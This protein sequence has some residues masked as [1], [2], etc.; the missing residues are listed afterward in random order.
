VTNARID[1]CHFD[2]LNWGFAIQIGGWIYGV[3]DHNLMECVG[4]GIGRHIDHSIWGGGRGGS[5]SWAD[6]PY[7]GSEKFWFVEDNTTKGSG[8]ANTSGGTDAF[9][10]GRYVLRHNYIQN[11]SAGGHG[12]VGGQVGAHGIRENQVYNNTFNWTSDHGI[13]YQRSGI[14]I[15][16]DNTFTGRTWGPP[17]AHTALMDYR[18][19][20]NSGLAGW[21]MA[22]GENGWDNNDPHGV[23]LSGTAASNTT[24]HTFTTETIMAPDEFK[25]M[26]VRNDNPAAACYL[27]SSFIKGNTVTT[28]TYAMGDAG[29]RLLFNTGD[30]FSIRKPLITVD[31]CGR[32]KGDLVS[33]GKQP[34][35]WPNQQQETCFSWNDVHTDGTAI[36]LTSN[37][38]TIHQGSDYINLGKGFPA[39]TI[40]AQVQAAY[41]AS[42]NG[43]AYTQEYPY[44][45]PLTSGSPIPTPT[46]TPTPTPSRRLQP[47]P[48]RQPRRR[49]Q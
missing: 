41:P 15:W 2:H 39:N 45:H 9:E 25:G 40:P 11:S 10:G 48:Q 5:G 7:F 35:H 22:D 4:A 19:F 44:P 21:G 18:Q 33:A 47:Q 20:G 27:K 36:G 46:A 24:N 38:P 37:M 43:V 1:H 34:R 28:I 32:G 12:T 17:H 42:V 29:P 6:F 16:H 14:T 30:A 23:Y 3:E 49:P 13:H 8:T 26:Q 31:Q